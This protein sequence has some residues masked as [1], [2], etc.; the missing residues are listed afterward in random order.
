MNKILLYIA[1]IFNSV[2]FIEASESYLFELEKEGKVIHLYGTYH[3]LSFQKLPEQI[4]SNILNHKVLITES[5]DHS[6]LLTYG[7][8]KNLGILHNGECVFERFDHKEKAELKK[9]IVP[10]LQRK[11]SEITFN[12]LNLKGLL[13]LYIAGHFIEGMDYTLLDF[14][15]DKTIGGLESRVALSQHFVEPT[16]EQFK[17]A[18]TNKFGFESE[19]A[20]QYDLAYLSGNLLLPEQDSEFDSE[21]I[22]RNDNWIKPII[23]YHELYAHDAIICVG[24]SHLYDLLF[25]L[26]KRGFHIR[27]AN[28]DGTFFP[29]L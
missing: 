20:K 5:T 9:Y 25:K 4:Q 27:R 13:E 3:G 7:E 19:E 14:F 21:I 11:K 1:F 18:L 23:Q 10:F 22:M 26:S 17:E 16:F 12:D 8:C 2:F 28:N 6:S 29:Y 24:V 15:K